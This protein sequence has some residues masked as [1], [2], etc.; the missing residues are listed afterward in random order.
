MVI[1][2][3]TDVS[4]NRILYFLTLILASAILVEAFARYSQVSPTA[5]LLFLLLGASAFAAI[6]LALVQIYSL[7]KRSHA[8]I[9]HRGD[10]EM[11]LATNVVHEGF[12]LRFLR[13]VLHEHVF[14]FSDEDRERY[15]SL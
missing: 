1:Q 6:V 9:I 14:S 10:E 11:V 4:R 3:R 5:Q 8:L 13:D 2:Q 7:P 15:K 12:K